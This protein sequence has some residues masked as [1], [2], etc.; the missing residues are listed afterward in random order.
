M[1]S[2]LVFNT[3]TAEEEMLVQEIKQGAEEE[4]EEARRRGMT[5]QELRDFYND[6]CK[7][8]GLMY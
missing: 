5:V 7:D 4:A 6:L 2:I 1:S 3:N 8:A